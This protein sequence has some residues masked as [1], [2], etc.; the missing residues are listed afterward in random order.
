ML[1]LQ[2]ERLKIAGDAFGL[3]EIVTEWRDSHAQF[4]T[5]PMTVIIVN[6]L[7]ITMLTLH[8]I[9]SGSISTK[10]L[11]LLYCMTYNLLLRSKIPLEPRAQN[12]NSSPLFG[13]GLYG[14]EWR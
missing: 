1:K 14:E 10:A 8:A 3:H 2:L 12:S 9:I 7:L 11:A 6:S 4:T 13:C 5:G